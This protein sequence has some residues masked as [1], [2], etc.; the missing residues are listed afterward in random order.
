MAKKLFSTFFIG[1][2]IKNVLDK[3]FLKQNIS[4]TVSGKKGFICFEFLGKI[5]LQSKKQVTEI[6]HTCQ[7]NIK[8]NV[9]FRSS[10][11]ISN[12]FWFKDKIPKYM[13]SE[14]DL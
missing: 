3:L 1:Y 6:F 14:S 7:K 12:A 11:R 9:V 5:S 2:C 13:N 8:W 10:N 4:G